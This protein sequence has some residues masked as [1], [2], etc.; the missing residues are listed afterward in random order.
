MLG[1][2]KGNARLLREFFGARIG[3]PEYPD[4]H[5]PNDRGNVVAVTVEV[6][7]R[8]VGLQGPRSIRAVRRFEIHRCP[9]DQLPQE[10]VIYAEAALGIHDRKK[11]PGHA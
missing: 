8:R 3:V 5:Q 7:K 6:G 10:G 4:A 9:L 1:E 11:G 2:L